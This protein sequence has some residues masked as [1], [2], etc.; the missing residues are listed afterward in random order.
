MHVIISDFEQCRNLVA[1][2]VCYNVR[3]K[4]KKKE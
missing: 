1:K 2:G 3:V 4:N